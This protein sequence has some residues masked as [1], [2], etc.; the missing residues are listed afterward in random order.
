MIRMPRL[1]L[2]IPA[3][4]T[5]ELRKRYGEVDAL[6]RLSVSVGRGEVFGFLGPNGAGR[7]VGRGGVVGFG[8]SYGAGRTS[9]VK[10][11]LGVAR[12]TTGAGKGRG[13]AMG[14]L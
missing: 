11:L 4:E 8:G 13:G 5:N 2:E 1:S 10:V 7:A 12:P 6:A 9:T 14:G 3:I